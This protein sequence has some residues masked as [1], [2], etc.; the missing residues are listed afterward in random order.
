MS[1]TNSTIPALTDEQLLGAIE[2]RLETATKE[3][4]ELDARRVELKGRVDALTHSLAVFK[5]DSTPAPK[6]RATKRA[7]TGQT[8][9]EQR[10]AAKAAKE[11]AAA[12]AS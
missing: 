6:R 8:V 5:G 12:A 2:L 3:L 7:A 11:A 4:A 1:S 9:R 10:A